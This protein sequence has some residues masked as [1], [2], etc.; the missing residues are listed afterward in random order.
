MSGV[1]VVFNDNGTI[2]QMS[3]KEWADLPYTCRN[4]FPTF[5]YPPGPPLMGDPPTEE[6]ASRA[7]MYY[8]TFWG[9]QLKALGIGVRSCILHYPKQDS[10]AARRFVL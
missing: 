1:Q 5:V 4:P 7:L 9:Y 3:L 2:R 8:L 6:E 10:I